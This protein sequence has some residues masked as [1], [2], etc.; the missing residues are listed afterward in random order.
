MWALDFIQRLH[1]ALAVENFIISTR[2]ERSSAR[3]HRWKLSLGGLSDGKQIQKKAE[4]RND[5]LSQRLNR[6]NVVG[7]ENVRL[8]GCRFRRFNQGDI[9]P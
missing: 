2:K 5:R 8:A 9:R 1:D 4:T 3:I 7:P 6:R